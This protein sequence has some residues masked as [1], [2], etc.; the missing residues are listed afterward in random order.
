MKKNGIDNIFEFLDCL[1]QTTLLYN[2]S[3]FRS[4]RHVILTSRAS[5]SDNFKVQWVVKW[6]HVAN[7]PSKTEIGVAFEYF[8]KSFARRQK[9]IVRK[10]IRLH[11]A[12]VDKIVDGLA[13]QFEEFHLST[14]ES[15]SRHGTLSNTS[16][17]QSMGSFSSRSSLRS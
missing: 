6:S 10:E 12:D 2:S 16:R 9:T 3:L 7:A 17:T 4:F 15:S 5:S 11:S 14:S 8:D 13:E 1:I